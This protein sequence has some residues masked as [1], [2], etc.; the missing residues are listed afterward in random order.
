MRSISRLLP[1]FVL[2]CLLL[3]VGCSD[4]SDTEG[5]KAPRKDAW[6]PVV[7]KFPFPQVDVE[8]QGIA[9]VRSITIGGSDPENWTNRGDVEVFLT[10]PDNEIT[11]EMRRFTSAD[12]ETQASENYANMSLWAFATSGVGKPGD[13]EPETNCTTN[14]VWLDNCQ[15]RV[16]Y[17]GLQQPIRDGADL[18]VTLPASYDGEIVIN[19]SDNIEDS[20]YVDRSDVTVKGLRGNAEITVDSGNV[21]VFMARDALPGETICD[22]AT[23]DACVNWTD[24][25][26]MEADPWSI[27]CPCTDYG[28]LL[29]ASRASQSSNIT[30][31]IPGGLWATANSN[32]K[33][34]G[35]TTISTP[36]CT[37]ETACDGLDCRD[38]QY[39]ES[40]PWRRRT[41]FNDPGGDNSSAVEAG[42]YNMILTSESCSNVDF[43]PTPESFEDEPEVEK[44]GDL[45]VCNGCLDIPNP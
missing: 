26:T 45:L 14:G 30:V 16:Y 9:G 35:L 33:Q 3:A 19:T 32:N 27:D 4:D 20:Q 41:E 44:R 18:R 12:S 13:Q 7:D 6:D 25:D 23:I 29:I 10:G 40:Q 24:P 34:P 38:D 1:L 21:N 15:I 8:D 36:T 11:V 43:H 42:G 2:P 22:P 28:S 39:E 37:A 5:T 17:D 31:D